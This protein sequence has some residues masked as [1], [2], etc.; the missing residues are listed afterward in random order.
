M[1]YTFTADEVI[2]EMAAC[3]IVHILGVAVSVSKGRRVLFL[4]LVSAFCRVCVACT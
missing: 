3:P 1:L 4:D 2:G